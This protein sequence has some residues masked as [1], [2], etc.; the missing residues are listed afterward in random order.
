MSREHGC[1]CSARFAL[2][3]FFGQLA[4]AEPL[5]VL[6]LLGSLGRV[7]VEVFLA[8]LRQVKVVTMS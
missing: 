7:G 4:I 8:G 5:L 1:R 6:L 3:Y 2:V